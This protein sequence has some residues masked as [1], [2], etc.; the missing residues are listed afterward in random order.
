MS[1]TS[2]VANKVKDNFD[3]EI[4]ST[5]LYYAESS[6]CVYLYPLQNTVDVTTTD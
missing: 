3:L 2:S 4:D 5:I 6:K 1:P